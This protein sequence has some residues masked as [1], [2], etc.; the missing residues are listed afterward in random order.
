METMTSL[1]GPEVDTA[2][3]FQTSRMSKSTS[4]STLDRVITSHGSTMAT[5]AYRLLL[6]RSHGSEA[7]LTRY[8]DN[9][10][11]RGTLRSERCMRLERACG[12]QILKPRWR[13]IR[14]TKSHPVLRTDTGASSAKCRPERARSLLNP[15]ERCRW[16]PVG[17]G[18][19]GIAVERIFWYVRTTTTPCARRRSDRYVICQPNLHT[20]DPTPKESAEKFN[21]STHY[22]TA[23]N[24]TTIEQ[25]RCGNTHSNVEARACRSTPGILIGHSTMRCLV[26]LQ[27]SLLATNEFSSAPSGTGRVK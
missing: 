15:M 24:A 21:L 4:L 17:C 22:Q 5:R 8:D 20:A 12:V 11:V 18:R 27:T 26:R 23:E 13:P 25:T 10:H 1:L 19:T 9:N 6:T 7:G 2:L 16:L 14:C 3:P